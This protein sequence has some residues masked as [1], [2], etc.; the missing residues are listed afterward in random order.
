MIRI[1]DLA[2]ASEH[3]VLTDAA[4]PGISGRVDIRIAGSVIA[5]VS[6]AGAAAPPADATIVPLDG[7]VVAPAF[8]EPHLHLDK[9]LLG[10][11]LGGGDLG[12]AIAYT[13]ERKRGFTSADVRARAERVLAA[14]LRAGTTAIR[15]QT[16]VDPT[17]GLLSIQVMRELAERHRSWL[18]LQIAVFPQ[19]GI[20]ARAGT[21]P[22]MREALALPGTIVGG[23]PYTEADAVDARAHVDQV[24]DLAVEFGT[25]ADLHLD[26]ADDTSDQRFALAGYVARATRERGLEDRVAIGHVTTLAA[27]HPSERG[28]VLDELARAGVSVVVLPATDL[29]LMGRSDAANVRRGIA[30]VSDLWAHGVRTALSSNNLRNAFTPTGRADP[31][32]IALLA[33]RVGFASSR[34]DFLRLHRAVTTDAAAVVGSERARGLAAGAPAD[35]V[36]F[37]STDP[38]TVVL[39]QPTRLLVL[40]GGRP[41]YSARLEESFHE[42][43]LPG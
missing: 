35:L 26:L 27:M 30:P 32:D 34:E 9:A 21:L 42:V 8:V 17:V 38:D 7:R 13:A 43:P 19:E 4:A 11:P 41:V 28:R 37:D 6:P 1:G 2:A 39:D 33:G 36:V 23:C 5:D 22:L 18:D 15:A 14:A 16:E 40:A 3:I 12:A 25:F 31:L 24:L 20:R 10:T 29:Y